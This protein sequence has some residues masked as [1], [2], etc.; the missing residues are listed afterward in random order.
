MKK[1]SLFIVSII[2][3][4][5][6]L[7]YSAEILHQTKIDMVYPFKDGKILVGID[8][9]NNSCTNPNEFY[10]VEVGQAGVTEDAVD[11]IY[12]AIL[13][14]AA[15]Q[16]QVEIIFEPSTDGQCYISRLKVFY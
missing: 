2:L 7:A 9:E 14:A 16:N 3:M 10:R 15:Q 5:S 8:T 1:Y 6:D 11:R 13:A 4:Y 12:A